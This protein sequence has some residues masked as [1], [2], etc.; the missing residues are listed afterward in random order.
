MNYIADKNRNERKQVMRVLF[1][2]LDRGRIIAYKYLSSPSVLTPSPRCKYNS[3]YKLYIFFK[4][5]MQNFMFIKLII[6]MAT[7][8]IYYLGVKII[9]DH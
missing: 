2:A 7:V 9:L 3:N 1:W 5:F 6:I 8:T 4:R